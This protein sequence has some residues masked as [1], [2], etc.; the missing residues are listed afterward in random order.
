MNK[1]VGRKNSIGGFEQPIG[2]HD[3]GRQGPVVI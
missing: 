3:V 1:G 2:K